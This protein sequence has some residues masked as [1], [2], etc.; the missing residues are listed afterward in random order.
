MEFPRL[1]HVHSEAHYP[2]GVRALQV[3]KMK[4]SDSLKC[5]AFLK[6]TGASLYEPSLGI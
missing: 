4:T 1:M 6:Q 2:I 3:M 5:A